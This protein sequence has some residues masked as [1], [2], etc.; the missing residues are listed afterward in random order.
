MKSKLRKDDCIIYLKAEKIPLGKDPY[1]LT[2][3]Q[4]DKI[5]ELSKRYGYKRPKT[6]KSS[7][8][9]SSL[10]YVMLSKYYDKM[11]RQRKTHLSHLASL[12]KRMK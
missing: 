4:Q 7:L 11:T 5:S 9:T 2:W 6:N 3:D 12:L 8:A 1:T 10:F